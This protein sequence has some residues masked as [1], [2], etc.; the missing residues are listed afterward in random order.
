MVE[1]NHPSACYSLGLIHYSGEI[2]PK[3]V[4]KGLLL[5]QKGA[6]YKDPEAN[7]WLAKQYFEGTCFVKDPA[8]GIEHLKISAGRGYAKACSLLG[9]YLCQGKYLQ[10]DLV[11]GISYIRSVLDELE[12]KRLIWLVSELSISNTNTHEQTKTD[13]IVQLV[14]KVSESCDSDTRVAMADI[15]LDNHID[16]AFAETLLNAEIKA[17]NK[18]AKR[19][20]GTYYLK[21]KNDF[22]KALPLLEEVAIELDDLGI[23]RWL[24]GLYLNVQGYQNI[25]KAI[26]F[27]KMA[28]AH[29]D[30]ESCWLLGS[31]YLRD[32]RNVDEGMPLIR[33]AAEKKYPIAIE[34]LAYLHKKLEDEGLSMTNLDENESRRPS[35]NTNNTTT[36][37]PH[38][39]ETATLSTEANYTEEPKPNT[40][41][42]SGIILPEEE[43]ATPSTAV[44]HGEESEPITTPRYSSSFCRIW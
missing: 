30:P 15:L 28:A 5:I 14:K 34:F 39:K 12:N 9:L 24:G 32:G 26:V 19:V 33:I 8:K 42:T 17:G 10:K 13:F 37:I 23:Q 44:E 22:V 25:Q 21:Q 31:I 7:Y 16:E 18:E 3:D 11:Q 29:G 4:Q 27:L 1:T 43:I 2:V 6:R 20:L 40:D 41:P 38:D 35:E 36:I